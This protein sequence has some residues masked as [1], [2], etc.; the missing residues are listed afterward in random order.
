VLNPELGAILG[1]ERFLSEIQVTANLQHPNLLPLFDS[2]EAN[3]LLFYVMPYVE[4]ETLRARLEREKQLPVDEAVHIA[5][6]VANALAYAHAHGV[7]HRDLKPENILLH[8]GQPVIADFGIA[9]AVSNAGG[10]RITQTGLSLGTPQYMSPE[11]ATGDRAIDGRTDIYSLGAMTYEMLTGDPPHMGSTAQ[12]IMARVL[13]ERP[14]S[15]RVSRPAIPEHVDRA[16]DRALEKLPADRFATAK[17][18]CDALNGKSTAASGAFDERRV[19]RTGVLQWRYAGPAVLAAVAAAFAAGWWVSNRERPAEPVIRFAIE[20]PDQTA[21]TIFPNFTISPDGMTVVWATNATRPRLNIRNLGDTAVHSLAAADFPRGPFFSPDG[22]WIGFFG[23]SDVR[24]VPIGGG[25]P[26]VVTQVTG[27]I[28]GGTWG[29]DDAIVYVAN[30]TIWVVSSNGGTPRQLAANDGRRL[31]QSFRW[32][33]FTPDGK[34]ILYTRWA[35][36]YSSSRIRGL[37]YSDGTDVGLDI[38]GVQVIGFFGDRLIYSNSNGALVA[39]RF[40]QRKATISG[41]AVQVTDGVLTTS[42]G[43]THATLSATGTLLYQSGSMAS[44]IVL[45]NGSGSLTTIV[46]DRTLGNAPY[47]R[48]SPDGKRI[49]MNIA[50]AGSTDIWIAEVATGALSRLSSD[51]SLSERPEWTA[52][53]TRILY[54]SAGT[55]NATCWWQAADGSAPASELVAVKDIDVLECALSPDGQYILYR[56][57]TFG[58]AD[59]QFRRLHGDTTTVIPLA[60]NPRFNEYEGR[61]SPDGRWV[62]YTSDQSGQREVYVVAFPNVG[63]RIL[64]ST[65]GGTEP[66]WS[67]DGRLIYRHGQDFVAAT[68]RADPAFSVVRRDVMFAGNFALTNGHANYDVTRAGQLILVRPQGGET[69][70]KLLV[71]NWGREVEARLKGAR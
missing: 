33:H 16:I 27:T 30:G 51:G 28:Y 25:D 54:R 45:A 55:R 11:Q 13:T 6:A 63:A 19:S 21:G 39:Q 20:L 35:G 14:R 68:F 3:G 37:R 40:N 41:P 9:L 22:K 12:A 53:G 26:T 46:P 69:S 60:A 34:T 15:T 65:N 38:P 58:G 10:S 57:G 62:A 1:V 8:A 44:S 70:T 31:D 43:A 29:P 36:N 49:A 42:S 47:P 4:G 71:Y 48:V 61:F 56:T 7:I 64:V 59:I 50:A 2:G 24:K 5:T 17:D 52:D 23:S 32:P 66:A 18:F 67:R